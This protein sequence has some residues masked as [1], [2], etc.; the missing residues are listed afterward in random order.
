MIAGR[1][2]VVIN[3]G[4]NDQCHGEPDDT[5]TA[6]YVRFVQKIRAKLPTTE[7]VALRPC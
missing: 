5:M 2:I 1:R 6:S 7:I 3:L 4:Q